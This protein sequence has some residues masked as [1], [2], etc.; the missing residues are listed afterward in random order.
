MNVSRT[1]L[2]N[3]TVQVSNICKPMGKMVAKSTWKHMAKGIANG[4]ISSTPHAIIEN[5][6]LTRTTKPASAP[7]NPACLS[8]AKYLEKVRR[9]VARCT[10]EHARKAQLS[11]LLPAPYMA[12]PEGKIKTK[13]KER[14]QR[15]FGAAHWRFMPV[16]SGFGSV[17][18]DLLICVCGRFIAIETKADPSKK[19]TPLQQTTA[20]LI[21]SAGGLVFVVSDDA[22]LDEAIA[23]I[24]LA[25]EFDSGPTRRKEDP[26]KA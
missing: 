2:S 8:N 7:L 20:A 6:C 4:A 11:P 19:L 10:R 13:V 12:T 21:R 3:A 24:R 16:Q 25:L 17:A 22:S 1:D 26:G 23:K 5:F 9:E 18:L 14:L 15:E